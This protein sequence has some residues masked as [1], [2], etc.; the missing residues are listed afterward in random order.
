[1]RSI[2][3]EKAENCS[4]ELAFKEKKHSAIGRQPN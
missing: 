4:P 3:Y 2:M 1:M